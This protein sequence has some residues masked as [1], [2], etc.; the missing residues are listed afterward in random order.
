MIKKLLLTLLTLSI[1]ILHGC[2]DE[3]ELASEAQALYFE[4]VDE[5]D[6]AYSYSAIA[7]TYN[8]ITNEFSN[9]KAKFPYGSLDDTLTG[10]LNYKDA[11]DMLV[12]YTIDNVKVD[13][14]ISGYTFDHLFSEE[15]T[16]FLYPEDGGIDPITCT[17]KAQSITD[18]PDE[19]SSSEIGEIPAEFNSNW[20]KKGYFFKGKDY[21]V[22]GDIDTNAGTIKSSMYVISNGTFVNQTTENFPKGIMHTIVAYK[23]TLH[24]YGY[25]GLDETTNTYIAKQEHWISTDGLKWAQEASYPEVGDGIIFSN[26][27]V[28]KNKLWFY[29]GSKI[30]NGQK[31]LELAL[32]NTTTASSEVNL[33][34]TPLNDVLSESLAITDTVYS[35][36]DT[37][38][39]EGKDDIIIHYHNI[40][41]IEKNGIPESSNTLF[42]STDGINFTTERTLDEDMPIRFGAITDYGRTFMSFG[43]EKADGEFSEN[44]WLSEDMDYFV[45]ELTPTAAHKNGC[46]VYY[47]DILFSYGG[48]FTFSAYLGQSESGNTT[49]W[50]Y[51]SDERRFNIDRSNLKAAGYSAWIN[52]ETNYLYVIGAYQYSTELVDG[53]LYNTRIG[54]GNAFKG[55]F[56]SYQGAY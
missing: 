41:T 14:L 11:S 43:G 28:F 30:N 33:D 9:T 45:D 12:R 56:Y 15:V 49:E 24:I 17:I 1:F 27:L 4:I 23:D 5:N 46:V 34:K 20:Y 55:I 32:Y 19:I 36:A 42:S 7:F 2:V 37:I 51:T 21:V 50:N 39:K 29:G 16:L 22:T 25:L 48:E 52:E 31:H 18:N 26:A 53:T 47:R 44:V 13:S 54:V 3:P 40:K 6:Y 10:Y 8:S 38:K 35:H